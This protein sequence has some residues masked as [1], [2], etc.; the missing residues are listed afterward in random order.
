MQRPEL[1]KIERVER[2]DWRKPLNWVL[3][4]KAFVE[5]AQMCSIA[6]RVEWLPEEAGDNNPFEEA[7][8]FVSSKLLIPFDSE[9]ANLGF[10]IA[11]VALFACL[12]GENIRSDHSPNSL[13]GVVLCEPC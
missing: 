7:L 5:F 4:G 11:F 6:A 9:M 3:S 8:R 13:P 2:V 12:V 10:A 1:C